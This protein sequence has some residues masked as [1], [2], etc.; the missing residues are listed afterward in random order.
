MSDPNDVDHGYS[1]TNQKS[2]LK[3]ILLNLLKLVSKYLIGYFL[4]LSEDKRSTRVVEFMQVL[5]S[6]R[7]KS[8]TLV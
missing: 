3:L 4:V 7:I 5:L 6:T 8:D 2:G 1:K